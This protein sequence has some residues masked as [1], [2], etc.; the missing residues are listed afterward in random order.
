[1]IEL[2]YPLLT[3]IEARYDD[4]VKNANQIFDA[5]KLRNFKELPDLTT[6]QMS[7]MN[8]LRE[9]KQKL[10]VDVN[11][12]AVKLNVIKEEVRLQDIFPFIS[13]ADKERLL[14]LQKSILKKEENLEISLMRNKEFLSVILA[15]TEEIINSAT[16]I[17]EKETQESHLFLNEEY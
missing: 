9:R 14:D 5:I 16:Y 4:V 1:M 11:E 7:L 8:A 3:D 12:L 6:E 10:K 2:L 15:S 13:Q 17:S